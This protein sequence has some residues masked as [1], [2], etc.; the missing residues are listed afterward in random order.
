[1]KLARIAKKKEK[2][3]KKKKKFNP[4]PGNGGEVKITPVR[5]LPKIAQ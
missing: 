5:F 1:L 3:K 2:K 4:Y